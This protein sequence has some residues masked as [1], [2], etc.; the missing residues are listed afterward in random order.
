VRFCLNRTLDDPLKG[1]DLRVRY[2]RR[3]SA[4]THDCV[5]TWS[6]ENGKPLGKGCA[7]ENIAREQGERYAF[8]AVFPLVGA[9]IQGQKSLKTFS[10]KNPMNALLVL[11]A[12]VKSVPAIA[13]IYICH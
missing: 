4:K 5:N 6:G 10:G 11:M 7:K 3:L 9:R 12:S 1:V 2:A 13:R 8:D